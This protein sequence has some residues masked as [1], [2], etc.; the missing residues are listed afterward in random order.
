MAI[1]TLFYVELWE[2]LRS[3]LVLSISDIPCC[4]NRYIFWFHSN[5]NQTIARIHLNLWIEWR[6][7]RLLFLEGSVIYEPLWLG[8]L[9]TVLQ[10]SLEAKW[11]CISPYNI[12]SV[13]LWFRVIP[14][15]LCVRFPLF[16][17]CVFTGSSGTNV[18]NSLSNMRCHPWYLWLSMIIKCSS[19]LIFSGHSSSSGCV[20]L[21]SPPRGFA[22]VWESIKHSTSLP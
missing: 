12:L 5:T 8:Q 1:P 2:D 21:F 17:Y 7:F 4:K 11:V 19:L 14:L 15:F 20:W 16:R 10:C 6:N 13:E 22:P 3:F 18:F 9:L